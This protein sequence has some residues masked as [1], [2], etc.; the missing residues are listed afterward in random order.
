MLDLNDPRAG[1]IAEAMANK[2]AKKVLA[3][4]AEKEMSGSEIASSLKIPLN[5]V[6]YNLKK[7]VS[8]GLVEKTKKIFWSSRGKKMEIYKLANKRIIISPKT[9]AKGISQLKAGDTL[10][11][12]AGRY[13]ECFWVRCKGTA[14]NRILIGPA[15]NGEVIIDAS[16]D[17]T[18]WEP[19]KGQIYKAYCEFRPAALVV[20]ECPLFPEFSLGSM[21]EGRWFSGTD[22]GRSTPINGRGEAP[23]AAM[24][25]SG[26]SGRRC[27]ITFPPWIDFHSFANR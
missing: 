4:L 6:G 20:D 27:A 26:T 5:T 3:L 17:I 25:S 2:T 19:Y 1:E 22:I 21:N 9:I 14:D 7:L 11:I 24:S 18:G 23:E 8:A 12:S 13:K 10:V 15:G 16:A